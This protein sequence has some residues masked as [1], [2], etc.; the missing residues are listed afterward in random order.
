MVSATDCT[1]GG[2]SNQEA[3]AIIQFAGN[4]GSGDEATIKHWGPGHH[5]KSDC[6]WEIGTVNQR[7]EV[8]F[9]ME[10]TVAHYMGFW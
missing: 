4:C 8:G 7:G 9:N 3:T 2:F 6:C 1:G 5:S 10:H